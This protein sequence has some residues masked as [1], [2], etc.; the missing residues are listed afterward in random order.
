MLCIHYYVLLVVFC[1]SDSL[2]YGQE[3]PCF[4]DS[5]NR[6]N[7]ANQ[8]RTVVP[9]GIPAFVRV[10]NFQI[11]QVEVIKAN[12]FS[13]LSEM[14]L[15]RFDSNALRVIEPK[16]FYGMPKLD[17]LVLNR[18]KITHFDD[19]MVDPKSP[20]K[21]GVSITGN[22][23]KRFPL[24]LLKRHRVSINTSNNRIKCDCFTVIPDDLKE[25]V[26][27]ECITTEGVKRTINSVRYEDVNCQSCT[28]KGCVHGS[29]IL[30]ESGTA[31]CSCFTGYTGPM[32]DIDTSSKFPGNDTTTTSSLIQPTPTMSLG[33]RVSSSSDVDI[34]P[35]SK[36]LTVAATSIELVVSSTIDIRNGNQSEKVATKTVTVPQHLPSKRVQD[37]SGNLHFIYFRV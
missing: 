11:N 35:S 19:S 15:L 4:C 34:R 17:E 16:A 3:C 28:Q 1:L 37:E 25:L 10:I 5:S 32:C 30:N 12:T 8:A 14:V 6:M 22:L 29:C 9:N 13:G 21:R 18:N 23:L 24:N 2:C 26:F 36:M 31:H 7:C 27:G 33:N 20:L